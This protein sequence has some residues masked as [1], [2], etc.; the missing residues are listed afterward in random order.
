MEKRIK[1]AFERLLAATIKENCEKFGA[2]WK[3]TKESI[4]EAGDLEPERKLLMEAVRFRLAQNRKEGNKHA[5]QRK[6]DA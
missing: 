3:Q 1:G 2:R 6:A 5:R 4:A